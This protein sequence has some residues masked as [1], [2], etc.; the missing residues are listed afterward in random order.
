VQIDI[1]A[2][3]HLAAARQ[4]QLILTN[5]LHGALAENMALRRHVSTPTVPFID[6]PEEASSNGGSAHDTQRAPETS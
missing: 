2:E 5:A 1:T 3:D 6:V 4:I